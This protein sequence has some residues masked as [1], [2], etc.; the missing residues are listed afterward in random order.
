MQETKQTGEVVLI[1]S[2]KGGTGKSTF[3]ANLASALAL[4]GFATAAVD[5]N[6]G[7]R[8]LDLFLGLESCIIYDLADA[9]S[10]LCRLKQAMVRDK[11]LPETLCLL[12]A[13]QSREKAA[14]G[15][16]HEVFQE[17]RRQFR[18]ILVDGPHSS[19]DALS[20]LIPEA[21]RAVLLV[22]PDFASLRSADAMNRLL[23]GAGLSRRSFV[24]NQVHTELFGSPLIPG[25]EHMAET[26]RI[27]LA[28]VIPYDV[29][30][31]LA[32]NA[33]SPLALEEGNYVQKNF[34]RIAQNLFQV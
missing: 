28:G 23:A 11:R 6:P 33:G 34:R 3:A 1:T 2:G 31:T 26:L 19:G 15:W 4:K 8:S 27:P 18:Y 13:P 30:F 7:C 32:A 21:D 5:A 25:M 17:L 16:S 14:A 9:A 22:C 20:A 24:V 29:N 10:G 12:S